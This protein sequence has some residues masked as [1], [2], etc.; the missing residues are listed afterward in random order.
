MKKI[1]LIFGLLALIA[2]FLLILLVK[3]ALEPK[4]KVYLQKLKSGHYQLIVDR[5][6]YIVKGV[7]YSPI[8]IGSSHEYD[9]WSDPHTPWI[10]D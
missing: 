6:P 4:P 10:V 9:W 7:C 3:V 5:K 1:F 8:P 2:G